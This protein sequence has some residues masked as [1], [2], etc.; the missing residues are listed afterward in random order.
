MEAGA[1]FH[2]NGIQYINVIIRQNM[3]TMATGRFYSILIK[4]FIK[5]LSFC[6]CLALLWLGRKYIFLIYN[7]FFKR[8]LA[9]FFRYLTQ[10][11]SLT[12]L[13]KF[14]TCG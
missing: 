9:L 13:N 8:L 10:Y 11:I 7:L 6:P 3:R 1:I 12:P 14:E 5:T 4:V 2:R